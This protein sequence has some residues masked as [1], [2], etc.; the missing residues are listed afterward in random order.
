MQL[1]ADPATCQIPIIIV[2]ARGQLDQRV[3]EMLTS[4]A[5]NLVIKPFGPADL[6][7]SD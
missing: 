3:M 1:R 7:E 5:E 2:T 6:I 4:N